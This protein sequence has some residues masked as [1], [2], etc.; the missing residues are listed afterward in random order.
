MLANPGLPAESRYIQC[1]SPTVFVMEDDQNI[2]V[3]HASQGG[4]DFPPCI[5]PDYLLG[6]C[7]FF[8]AAQ[9]IR[10][11]LRLRIQLFLPENSPSGMLQKRRPHIPR[12]GRM[13]GNNQRPLSPRMQNQNHHRRNIPR[14][15]PGQPLVPLLHIQPHDELLPRR[16]GAG[17]LGEI[18][19]DHRL[20]PQPQQQLRQPNTPLQQRR[21]RIRRRARGG[22]E[23]ELHDRL[24][25]GGCCAR[26]AFVS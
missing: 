23:V 13:H 26:A 14:V 20:P 11:L 3:F 21:W 1:S 7:L 15:S 18:P 25:H 4:E 8:P 22:A 12:P 5:A 6:L 17:P 2:R 24:G 16:R 19:R 10:Q 9:A